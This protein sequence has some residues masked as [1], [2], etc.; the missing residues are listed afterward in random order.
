MYPYQLSKPVPVFEF[1]IPT[2]FATMSFWYPELCRIMR[3]VKMS[4][5]FVKA[6]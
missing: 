5:E 3:N 2:G 6:Q 4:A 1:W